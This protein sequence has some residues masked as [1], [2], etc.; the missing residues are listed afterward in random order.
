MNPFKTIAAILSEIGRMPF[1]QAAY[2]LLIGTPSIV[3]VLV[4]MLPLWIVMGAV[5]LVLR[6]FGIRFEQGE[7]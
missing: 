7:D 1:P 3:I 6:I 2:A 5:A 4:F